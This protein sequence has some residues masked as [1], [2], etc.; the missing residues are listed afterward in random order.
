M[1]QADLFLC[2]DVDAGSTDALVRQASAVEREWLPE[3]LLRSVDEVFFHPSQLQVVA[4]RRTCFD[5]L[6]LS[7]SPCPLPEC[8]EPARVLYEAALR[9]WDKVFP[10]DDPDVA[11]FVTRVRCLT[12]WMPDGSL[13][14]LDQD[15]LHAVLRELCSRCRS[16]NQL[17]QAPWLAELQGRFDYSQLQFIEREA[18]DRIRVPSGSQV[19]LIY[20][21]GRPP[22]L[23]V[24]IQEVFGLKETPRV[25]GGR[26]RVLMHLLAP[27]MRPQ[28]VTD[29]LESFW[30]NTYSVVRKELARRYPRHSWPEDPTDATPQRKPGGKS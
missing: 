17:K 11:G 7:E 9:N 14:S 21:E 4:R 1:S 24:R 29:D 26:V 19:R 16:F 15:A 20:E 30:A 5:D 27:N 13:P 22:I 12:Q 3:R 10:T 8:D 18:P 28:Q 25:A 6:V 23:A 2:I